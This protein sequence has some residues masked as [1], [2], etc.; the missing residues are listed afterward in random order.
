[1]QNKCNKSSRCLFC[2]QNHLT[3]KH[4]CLL[5]TCREQQSCNHMISKCCNTCVANIYLN[6]LNWRQRPIEAYDISNRTASYRAQSYDQNKLSFDSI[7]SQMTALQVKNRKVKFF[8]LTQTKI[9]GET[10]VHQRRR[11]NHQFRQWFDWQIEEQTHTKKTSHQSTLEQHRKL[12]T[13][14][15]IE[16][17]LFCAWRLHRKQR[18][19][20]EVQCFLSN[21]YLFY[22]FLMCKTISRDQSLLFW[23]R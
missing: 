3:W 23:A 13:D 21:Y 16:I 1:L 6:T 10:R 15:K 20:K 22:L 9:D 11:K 18:C 17:E 12:H 2:E 19:F 14:A 4:K 8:A 7:T 5:L